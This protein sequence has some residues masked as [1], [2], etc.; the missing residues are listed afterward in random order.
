MSDPIQPIQPAV[1]P[2]ADQQVSG[3]AAQAILKSPNSV[4]THVVRVK[5]GEIQQ[6][7]AEV[8]KLTAECEKLTVERDEFLDFL[9]A[10][11]H[12]HFD[13]DKE[14]LLGYLGKQK[15]LRQLIAELE[16]RHGA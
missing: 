15:P 12:K 13:F 1:S 11:T 4:Q 14:E 3:D 8:K 6:L 5:D 16:Q 9:Y 10:L 2:P 7:K